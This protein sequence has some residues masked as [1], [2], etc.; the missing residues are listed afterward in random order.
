MSEQQQSPQAPVWEQRWHPLRRE[1]VIVASHRNTR[2]WSGK[3]ETIAT[4]NAPTYD[5]NCYLCPGNARV[6]G[7]HNPYY[8]GVYVFTNDHPPTGP[9]APEVYH[10]DGLYRVIPAHGVCRVVNYS[11]RHDLTLAELPIEQVVTLLDVWRSEY[12]L[13]GTRPEVNHVLIFENKGKEV[14]VSNPHPH[15]QIYATNFVFSLIEREEAAAEDYHLRTGRNIFLDI[16]AA[17]K[18]DGRR[19]IAETASAIAFVPQFARYAYEVY[20]MPK[21]LRH[22][23]DDLSDAELYDLAVTLQ[24]VLI[25]Y[26]NLFRMPFPYLLAVHQAPTDGAKHPYF[27]LHIELQPPLRQPGLLK[28]LAGPE[29]GG[30]NFLSDTSPEE[31]AAE[32]QAASEIHYL[33]TP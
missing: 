6:G 29:L 11:P 27:Q 1:W 18:H 4:A 21:Q 25:K 20:V 12:R 19:I 13:L 15:C 10:D 30:G 33:H 5:P 8:V 31:K 26:D 17:E 14:G 16:I 2:P 22:S 7:A 23:L 32:L 24:T 3:T 9:H 28:F